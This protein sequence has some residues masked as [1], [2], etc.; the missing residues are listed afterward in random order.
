MKLHPISD[1]KELAAIIICK[2]DVTTWM[3]HGQNTQ[4]AAEK[5]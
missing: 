2:K 5:E 1:Q 3:L 4:L